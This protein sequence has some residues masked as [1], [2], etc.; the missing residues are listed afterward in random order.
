MNVLTSFFIYFRNIEGDI[1]MIKLR[2]PS[3]IGNMGAGFDCL[4][5]A[6]GLYNELLVEY[7]DEFSIVIKNELP[8]ILTTEENLIYQSMLYFYK[9]V[10]KQ[11][12]CL[13]LT[14]SDKIPIEKGLGSSAACI[15]AGLIAA[16]ELTRQ[17]IPK[18]ELAQMACQ[19]EGH[20][21][22]VVPAIYGGLVI[23]ALDGNEIHHTKIDPS[24]ELSFAAFIPTD[25]QISTDEARDILPQEYTRA[26]VAFNISR[27]SMFVASMLTRNWDNLPIAVDDKIH[28]PYRKKLIP[29]MDEIFKTAKE[30]YAKGLFL[31]GAGPTI[32]AIIL[33]ENEHKFI[34]GMRQY[35]D[36]LKNTWEARILVPDLI[37]TQVISRSE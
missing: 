33:K 7:A 29:E 28:Q 13:K 1:I 6:V 19:I 14:Q 22:N 24:D 30:L 12:P 32:I 16:N 21:D 26:D 36:S 17:N 34:D 27:A 31:S 4:G 10:G 5:M 15:V 11:I 18:K 37:G 2:I 20:P 3:T 25:I 9:V 8:G 35:L 23:S